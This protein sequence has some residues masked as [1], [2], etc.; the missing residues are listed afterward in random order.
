M[1]QYSENPGKVY[2]DFCAFIANL[3]NV[4]SKTGLQMVEHLRENLAV[5]RDSVNDH[6]KSEHEEFFYATALIP[7]QLTAY[8][9][10]LLL[11]I[12]IFFPV[13]ISDFCMPSKLL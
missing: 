12:R 5:R 11:L 3:Q 9:I 13:R 8:N 7:S 6:L 2:I 10:I 1:Q 4:D